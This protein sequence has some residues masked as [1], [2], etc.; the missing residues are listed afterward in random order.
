M[1]FTHTPHVLLSAYQCAP[2]MEAV[3]EIGWQWYTRLTQ[4]VPVTLVTHI[5]NKRILLAAGAPLPNSEI[6]FIDTEWFAGPLFHLATKLFPED[7]HAIFLL[8][9]LD[10]Y[11]YDWVAVKHLR[12]YQR[13]GAHWDIAQAVTPV[14]PI[15]ATRLHVLKCPLV[16]GPWNGGLKTPTVFPEVIGKD[17]H[18]IY[19]IRHL[20]Y[21]VDWLAGTTKHAELILAATQATWQSI[22][23]RCHSRCLHFLENGVDLHLFAPAPWPSPPSNQN[24]LRIVFVGRLQRFK[25]L[26]LLLEAIAR[27]KDSLLIELMV[28]GGGILE[29]EWRTLA[30]RLGISQLVKWYGY[31]T[32]KQVVNELHKAHV[33]CL[34]SVRE[35]GGAV[36]LEAMACARPVLTIAYG[37]PKEVV[38]DRV[39]RALP[40]TGTAAIIDGLVESFRDIVIHPE[41]W[42]QRGENGR[43]RAETLYSWDA[44]ID[45]IL[46]IYQKLLKTYD[47]Q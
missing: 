20:G 26:T 15:A 7:E 5:R 43:K 22:P 24:P 36:I 10:F 17:R 32:A 19:P 45:Q 3:S 35:S 33:L 14:S 8:T 21:V 47:P 29:R 25:G 12:A 28:V 2:S 11:V 34:P 37:G 4:R 40:P 42:R 9:S 16:L 38:D 6:I 46:D 30:E 23:T 41:A 39:G 27:V 18:W 44:K 13:A 31:A 1:A